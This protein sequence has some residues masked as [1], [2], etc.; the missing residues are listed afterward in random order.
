MWP[1]I[2]PFRTLCN[3]FETTELSSHYMKVIIHNFILCGGGEVR[4]GLNVCTQFKR[5]A[6]FGL[7]QILALHHI[8]YLYKSLRKNCGRV[9]R[10]SVAM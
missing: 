7:R 5:D 1:E 4:E 2:V 10:E 6:K 8:R 3:T 9:V